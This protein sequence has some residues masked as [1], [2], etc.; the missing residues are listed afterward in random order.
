MSKS[1]SPRTHR[2]TFLLNDQEQRA[3]DRY[4]ERYRVHNRSKL[5]RE[6]L[7]R[8]VL[9]QFDRDSPTLF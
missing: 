4:C 9:K 7:I 2:M 3:V 8:A 5:A 6:A 1:P